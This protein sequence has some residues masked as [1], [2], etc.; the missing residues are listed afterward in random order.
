MMVL[1]EFEFM[2]HRQMYADRDVEFALTA[3]LLVLVAMLGTII[4]VNLILALILSD[5]GNLYKISH[6]KELFRMARQVR[7]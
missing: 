3:V 5:V 2:A 6:R 1:G 4:L 7:C